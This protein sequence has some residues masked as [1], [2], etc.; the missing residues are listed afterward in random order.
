MEGWLT[1]GITR[2]KF[3]R[4]TGAAALTAPLATAR[5]NTATTDRSVILLLLTGGPS[6]LETFD[7]KP[8]APLEIR[9]PFR[10]IAT[11]VPG[12][13]VSEHLPELARRMKHVAIVRTLHHDHAPIHETGL[14]LLQTGRL[15]RSE[16]DAA[17]FGA[18]A[19]ANTR[20]Y[21]TPTFALIPGPIGSTGVAI[22]HGQSAGP[23]GEMNAPES[24]IPSATALAYGS[25]PFARAC[26][27]ARRLVSAGTKVVV[28]NMY[29]SVFN[30][31]S[32]DCHGTSGFATLDD[33]A[34][35][36]VPD[37]DRAFAALIDDLHARQ[38]LDRTMVVATGE[39][40][41]GPRINPEGGRD[42]WERVWSGLIAGGSIAGGQVIGRSDAHAAEPEDRPFALTELHALMRAHLGL[43]R[44]DGDVLA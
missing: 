25:T 44:L 19:S 10:S 34:Q 2:R 23:L 3:I 41:R 28:V 13:R 43:P 32:W 38:M 6:Q 4:A 14:Q 16:A 33:Y 39:I 12:I 15:C 9:G 17:H 21:K 20:S 11:S 36:V 35:R 29:Q 42:H 1:D 5:A 30:T 27:E 40:G 18:V 24:V 26:F 22:P 37:F 31:L 8:D 7:P